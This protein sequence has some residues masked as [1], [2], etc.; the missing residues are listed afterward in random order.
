MIYSYQACGDYFLEPF[1]LR[2]VIKVDAPRQFVSCER[3]RS[4]YMKIKTTKRV[5][6]LNISHHQWLHSVATASSSEY[7][8]LRLFSSFGSIY[9]NQSQAVINALT[10]FLL[11]GVYHFMAKLLLF[12]VVSTANS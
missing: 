1:G 11:H 4:F 8:G 5:F 7:V 10:V 3:K 9:H 6:F 2:L 12:T